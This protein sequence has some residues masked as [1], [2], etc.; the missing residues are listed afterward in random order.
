MSYLL[1]NFIRHT[2]AEILTHC[3][4]HTAILGISGM[5]SEIGKEQVKLVQKI[6]CTL[7]SCPRQ[8]TP[9]EN[10]DLSVCLDRSLAETYD[11]RWN[12]RERLFGCRQG[13]EKCRR[14]KFVQTACVNFHWVVPPLQLF[15]S[16]HTAISEFTHRIK[17]I[18]PGSSQELGSGLAQSDSP[19]IARNGESRAGR[20]MYSQFRE[21]IHQA[22][23]LQQRHIVSTSHLS[24]SVSLA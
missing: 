2:T 22:R 1:A 3:G 20:C 8:A 19:A 5:L 10:N 6:R 23:P 17:S 21:F 12:L 15:L 11:K 18:F 13:G 4:Q 7:V 16:H 24:G 9:Q 14:R